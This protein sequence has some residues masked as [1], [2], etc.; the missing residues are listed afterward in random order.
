MK[1]LKDFILENNE[2]KEAKAEFVLVEPIHKAYDEL[3]D[4][5][6]DAMIHNQNG[7]PDLFV[8][9]PAVAKD[10]AKKYGKD[11]IIWKI[12]GNDLEKFESDYEDGK[13]DYNEL[14]EIDPKTLEY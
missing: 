6:A 7:D 1:S 2:I 10:M 3:V 12:P 11:V 8:L 5:M 14:E 4:E 9:T 13:F